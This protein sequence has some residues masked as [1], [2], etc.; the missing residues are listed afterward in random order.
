[1]HNIYV[2]ASICENV[3]NLDDNKQVKKLFTNL[4]LRIAEGKIQEQTYRQTK[5]GVPEEVF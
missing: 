2:S 3:E 4:D 1:M 5:L